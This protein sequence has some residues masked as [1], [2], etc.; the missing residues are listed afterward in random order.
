LALQARNYRGSTKGPC[1][2]WQLPN[3]ELGC[4][5]QTVCRHAYGTEESN[6]EVPYMA[7]GYK[8]VQEGDNIFQEGDNINGTR[9]NMIL[10]YATTTEGTVE[11]VHNCRNAA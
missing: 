11:Q 1:G 4:V 8:G 5:N 2:A 10:V 6:E 7:V 9:M 3:S